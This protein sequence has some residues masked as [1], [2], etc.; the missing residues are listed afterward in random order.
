MKPIRLL[1]ALVSLVAFSPSSQAQEAV[2][3]SFRNILRSGAFVA[4]FEQL[5][6]QGAAVNLTVTPSIPNGQIGTI[7]VVPGTRYNIRL[8]PD[9]GDGHLISGR[10]LVADFRARGNTPIPFNG[11]YDEDGRRIAVGMELADNKEIVAPRL[12]YPGT[13]DAQKKETTLTCPTCVP[14]CMPCECPHRSWW[15]WWR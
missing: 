3:V 5:D 4:Q 14:S 12:A 8:L 11:K 15:R 10:D 7:S 1:V 9:G 6:A 2:T 13:D